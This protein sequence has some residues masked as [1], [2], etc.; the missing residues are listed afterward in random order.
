MI[1][2][3]EL[4]NLVTV[5]FEY[6]SKSDYRIKPFKPFKRKYTLRIADYQIISAS[7]HNTLR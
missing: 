4:E 7:I 1:H 2:D 5:K 3:N 6:D